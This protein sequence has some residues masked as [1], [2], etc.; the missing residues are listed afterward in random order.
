VEA[1]DGFTIKARFK[2]VE[3]LLRDA[4]VQMAGIRIGSVRDIQFDRDTGKA[5]VVMELKNAYQKVIPE[6]SRFS[7]KTRGLLGDKYVVIEPGRPNGRKLEPNEEAPVVVESTDTEKVFET[8]GVVAQDLQVMTREARRQIIDE[9]GSKKVERIVGNAD[10][11]FADLQ[12]I[13][14]RNKDKI[15]QTIDNTTVAAA[16]L[17]EITGRNKDKINRSI[18]NLERFSTGM[19]KTNDR[20]ARVAGELEGLTKDVRSGRGTLGKLV[21]DDSLHRDAQALVRDFRGLASNVQNGQGSIGRLINDPE[22]YFEARRAIRNMNRTAEDVSES[23]PI[24]TLATILGAML[25]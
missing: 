16:D 4:Q 10:S 1:K 5:V 13:L 24:S 19:D 9:E 21:T 11:V 23:T 2:S 15:N 7:L 14:S 17:G 22:M 8:M 3:G 20:F 25:K 18:D 12:S 6:D